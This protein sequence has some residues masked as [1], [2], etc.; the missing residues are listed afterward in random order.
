MSPYLNE[1]A[2]NLLAR[3]DL[4]KA[5][6]YKMVKKF[7]LQEMQLTPS[8]YLDKFNSVSKGSNETYH[9]FGNRLASLFGI[10]L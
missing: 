2:K 3:S 7:L 6:D 4:D 8:V 10:T 1:R 5:A 9:Q